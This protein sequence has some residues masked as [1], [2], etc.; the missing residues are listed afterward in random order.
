MDL[1]VTKWH[2]AE[3][4]PSA[5]ASSLTDK[6]SEVVHYGAHKSVSFVVREPHQSSSYP[7]LYFCKTYFNIIF[8]STYGATCRFF[9]NDC[10]HRN[11]IFIPLSSNVC[12]IPCPPHPPWLDHSNYTWRRVQVMKLLIVQFF[13]PPLASSLI[14]LSTLCSNTLSL[15]SSLNV[16]YQV[17][18]LFF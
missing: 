1:W 7:Q 15:C 4:S 17:S 6:S 10:P 9:P 3:W 2:P 11:P 13:Q 8:L 18:L 14:L 16:S 12:Y 5:G